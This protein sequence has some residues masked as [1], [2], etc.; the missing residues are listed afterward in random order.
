MNKVLTVG[1]VEYLKAVRSKAFVIGV[2]LMPL[3]FHSVH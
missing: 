2:L 1:K 3:L